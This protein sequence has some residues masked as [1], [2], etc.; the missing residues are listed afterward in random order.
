MRLQ[1]NKEAAVILI[2]SD[3]VFL[4]KLGDATTTGF[5]FTENP[6]LTQSQ[7]DAMNLYEGHMFFL[8]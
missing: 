7:W 8:F 4:I 6:N 2:H 1:S 3:S 5:N